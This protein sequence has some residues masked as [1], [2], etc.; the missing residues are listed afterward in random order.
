MHWDIKSQQILLWHGLT[1]SLVFIGCFYTNGEKYIIT[2][3]FS[4]ATLVE[5][6]MRPKSGLKN[7]IFAAKE[8]PFLCKQV[9]DELFYE[10]FN[11][12]CLP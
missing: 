10:G 12:L 4:Q 1:R 6:C 8:Q 9:A 7:T 5:S 2:K 3:K 11:D